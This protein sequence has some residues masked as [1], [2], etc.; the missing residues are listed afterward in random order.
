MQHF[1]ATFEILGT[2]LMK[3]NLDMNWLLVQMDLVVGRVQMQQ[4]MAPSIYSKLN[5]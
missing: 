2:H 3:L 5:Q 4:C 1:N